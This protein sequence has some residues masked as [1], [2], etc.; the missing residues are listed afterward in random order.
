MLGF[1]AMDEEELKRRTK[2]FA[3]RAMKL[4]AALPRGRVPDNIAR[5]LAK[6]G[7]SVG[8]NYR[9][10]CIGR[11][12]AE[13]AAKIGI[14]AEEADVSAYWME[15]ILEGGLME[16]ELVADLLQ[17]ANELAAIC[18]RSAKTARMRSRR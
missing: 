10:A 9:S 17:E 13:F 14:A 15:L 18:A 2:Q 12:K 4:A 11:S 7:T 1:V 16:R 3:L 6:S 8:A 5:Q